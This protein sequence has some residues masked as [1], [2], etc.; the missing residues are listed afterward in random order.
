MNKLK[1]FAL[2][3]TFLFLFQSIYSQGLNDPMNNPILIGTH[4]IDFTYEDKGTWI[5]QNSGGPILLSS[6]TNKFYLFEIKNS[7]NIR[8][9]YSNIRMGPVS[10]TLYNSLRN[11]M[12]SIG[13][14]YIQ[15][16]IDQTI[17]LEIGKYYIET[18]FQP[19][20]NTDMSYILNVIGELTEPY[21]PSGP[22]RFVYDAAG[23]RITR[24]IVMDSRATET[25]E[26]ENI[27]FEQIATHEIKIYPNPTEG[28][29]KIEIEN[30]ENIHNCTFSITEV[31]SGKLILQE[32]AT[33]PVTNINISNQP[34]GVYIMI[35]DIDGEQSSWKIIKK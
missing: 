22:I 23:N 26:I 3:I 28:Q 29:L 35:I 5:K 4:E 2:A 12:F 15:I 31:N 9:K 8:I 24:E 13:K 18:D 34:T 30:P 14:E 10:I 33:L 20:M 21:I 27:L 11:K 25:T 19:G 1:H 6:P 7:M 16:G 32:Q 17:P